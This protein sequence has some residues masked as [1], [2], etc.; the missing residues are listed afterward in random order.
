MVFRYLTLCAALLTFIFPPQTLHAQG[1]PDFSN[2]EYSVTE[3][4]TF[5][6]YKPKG[7]KVATIVFQSNPDRM[8]L[9]KVLVGR[10]DE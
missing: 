6:L 5:G 10:S 8:R 9:K 7:W 3:E 2:Y 4:G 1:K